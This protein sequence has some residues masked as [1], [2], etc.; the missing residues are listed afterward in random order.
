MC[1]SFSVFILFN[2][3]A[4]KNDKTDPPL[5]LFFFFPLVFW[6]PYQRH[7]EVP[8]LGVKLELLLPAYA[9]A[10]AIPGLSCICNLHHS[11]WDTRSLARW[12]R[13]RIEPVSSGTL[14]RFITAEPGWK[15]PLICEIHFQLD[16]GRLAKIENSL[17]GCSLSVSIDDSS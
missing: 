17:F 2:I 11:P 10:T 6:G 12:V 15:L 16:F 14:V 8:R 5:N 3:A 13:P 9:T 7:M 1:S 4:K